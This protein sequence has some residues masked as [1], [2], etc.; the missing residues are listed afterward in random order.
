MS[1][2]LASIVVHLIFSTKA[3]QPVLMRELRPELFAYIAS[4]AQ[5]ESSFVF[6]IGGIE[7]H[8][9][10]LLS[11]P[12]TMALSRLVELIKKE[13]SKWLKKR[14]VSLQLFS[15]QK[16]GY[17]AFSVSASKIPIV[18]KYIQEQESHHAKS[19]FKDELLVF[20]NAAH[21]PFDEKYLWD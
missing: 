8:V 13:S 14:H 12:R 11:L 19:S 9:H 16:N 21:L 7:D 20:L 10:V 6:E 5:K 18:R 1:Q 4:L 17:G 15:W 3:R 2:S